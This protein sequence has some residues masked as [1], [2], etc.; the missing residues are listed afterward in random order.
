M[1]ESRKV[2]TEE[3]RQH[4]LSL[5]CRCEKVRE[6]DRKQKRLSE[7]REMLLT[8]E[9]TPFEKHVLWKMVNS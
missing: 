6:I 8:Y 5:A 9:L 1:T 3:V 2:Y 7:E 4:V